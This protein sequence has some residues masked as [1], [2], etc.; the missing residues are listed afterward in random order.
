MRERRQRSQARR[1]RSTACG[2]SVS[3]YRQSPGVPFAP[4]ERTFLRRLAVAA[5]IVLSAGPA[6]AVEQ[7]LDNGMRVVLIQHRANPMV[8]SAVVVGA[9]V[10]DEPPTASGAAHFLEHLLFNG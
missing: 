6:G 7:V 5:A 1:A 10:V 8:A 3:D 4:L 2:S 9:G